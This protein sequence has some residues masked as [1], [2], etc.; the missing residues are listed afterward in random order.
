VSDHA[1]AGGDDNVGLERELVHHVRFAAT[2]ARLA[3]D[4]EDGRD[5]HAGAR[6]DRLVAV[7]EA[8][9]APSRQLLADSG[10]AGAHHADQYQAAHA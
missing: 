3:L 6:D 7:G 2:K 1:A 4:L 9:L 10:L 8:Q 5:A